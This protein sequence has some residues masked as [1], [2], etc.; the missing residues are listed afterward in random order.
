[1]PNREVAGVLRQGRSYHVPV[2][3]K[4]RREPNFTNINTLVR[5]ENS[6]Y[7]R[8]NAVINR[9]GRSQSMRDDIIRPSPVKDR[10]IHIG[11]T[12]TTNLNKYECA[13]GKANKSHA[14]SPMKRGLS[15]Q[16]LVRKFDVIPEQTMSG[17]SKLA[18]S[19]TYI[20]AASA[21]TGYRS[22]SQGIS[23]LTRNESKA[24]TLPI[25]MH[26]KKYNTFNGTERYLG[27]QR[28]TKNVLKTINAACI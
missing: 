5:Q 26:P 1:V 3:S 23:R 14:V 11:L 16:E 7:S 24:S 8:E 13:V 21:S 18:S 27:N 2:S 19:H 9:R 20:P 15:V 10:R 12:S 25:S 17:A 4:L 6:K 28:N 22:L